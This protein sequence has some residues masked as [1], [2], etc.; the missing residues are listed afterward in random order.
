MLIILGGLCILCTLPYIG[1]MIAGHDRKEEVEC[2]KRMVDFRF[3]DS[4]TQE[5]V[6]VVLSATYSSIK[7]P[8]YMIF[9][10]QF[11]QHA[12]LMVTCSLKSAD[13]DDRHPKR[14]ANFVGYG[15]GPEGQTYKVMIVEPRKERPQIIPVQ[16][17]YIN[18]AA[19]ATTTKA[20]GV[21]TY[22]DGS[23]EVFAPNGDLFS[24]GW[25]RPVRRGKNVDRCRVSKVKYS[26]TSESSRFSTVTGYESSYHIPASYRMEQRYQIPAS[27]QTNQR[28][29][30]DSDYQLEQPKQVR[31]SP[32]V[33]AV[34]PRRQ[35]YDNP[36][37]EEED[38]YEGEV[39]R[40]PPPPKQ[41]RRRQRYYNLSES[42]KVK[43]RTTTY[44]KVVIGR[45]DRRNLIGRHD[46]RNLTKNEGQFKRYSKGYSAGY[47]E[48]FTS[49][50]TDIYNE[51]Y[52]K[53]THGEYNRVKNFPPSLSMKPWRLGEYDN[54]TSGLWI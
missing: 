35:Q 53:E 23:D 7:F 38:Y 4:P 42:A 32:P 21:S 8:T 11:R 47:D 36:A 51:M 48:G 13:E 33:H 6:T 46:S 3:V 12:R 18:F 2:L 17:S 28:Y 40:L 19:A 49:Q 20:L 37:F 5:L 30:L 29:R 9:N 14:P 39:P 25:V 45:H 22:D 10:T 50:K 34:Y 41:K 43:P 31:I 52:V 15:S 44:P 27:Y 26:R 16:P 1:F 54:G 24:D